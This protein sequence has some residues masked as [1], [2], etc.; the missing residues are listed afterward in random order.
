MY[1]LFKK[2]GEI[3]EVVIPPKM[4]KRGRKYIFV[5]FY[6]VRDERSLI[7]KLDNLLIEGRKLYVNLPIFHRAFEGV[8]SSDKIFLRRVREEEPRKKINEKFRSLR[9]STRTTKFSPSFREGPHMQM[10]LATQPN[11]I[12]MLLFLPRLL[13]SLF[14]RLVRRK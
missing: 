14:M 4:D 6:E 1:Q 12:I 5:R 9:N 10:L 2:F 3:N 11:N 13:K 7:L 8:F